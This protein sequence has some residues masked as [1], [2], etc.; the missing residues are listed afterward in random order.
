MK[1]TAPDTFEAVSKVAAD[2]CRE[3]KVCAAADGTAPPTDGGLDCSYVDTKE[4]DEFVCACSDASLTPTGGTGHPKCAFTGVWQD[5][6]TWHSCAAADSGESDNNPSGEANPNGDD[7]NQSGDE[8]NPSVDET[9]PS[10]GETNP[11]GGETNPSGGETNPSGGE[12]NPSGDETNPSSDETNSS[13]KRRRRQVE[14]D[15][16]FNI[17]DEEIDLYDSIHTRSKR[18]AS[19][20]YIKVKNIF[21]SIYSHSSLL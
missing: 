18:A 9:N 15:D 6:G 16:Y 20:N 14:S 7:T 3:P 8:T 13:G 12:T 19:A 17:D 5:P 11:S 2:D 4:F 21:I 1:C 10:G